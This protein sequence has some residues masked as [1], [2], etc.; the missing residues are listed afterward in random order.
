MGSGVL[1]IIATVLA[2]IFSGTAVATLN[3]VA[4]KRKVASEAEKFT[5][6]VM[7]SITGA[8][9]QLLEPLRTEVQL[10]RDQLKISNAEVS[11]LRTQLTL[12]N[13]E[14]SSTRKRV[15]DLEGQVENL[16]IKLERA[17]AELLQYRQ[18]RP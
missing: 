8:S 15:Q 7:S 16:T 18:N 6:D 2:A 3:A 12:A 4:Q 17:N 11:T 5:A 9:L 14:L 10:L 13:E 1:T